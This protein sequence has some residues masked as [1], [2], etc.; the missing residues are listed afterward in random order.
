[1]LKNKRFNLKNRN[2]FFM[3]IA[4]IVIICIVN[5]LFTNTSYA[6][7]NILDEFSYA[8]TAAYLAGYDWTGLTSLWSYYYS[9]GY[10]L[11]LAPIF[12]IFDNFNIIYYLVLSLNLIF[13]IGSF[14]LSIRI[15]RELFTDLPQW[16][17]ILGC[18]CINLYT[19]NLINV[20][21]IWPETLIVFL[22][23]TVA[24]LLLKITQKT[25]YFRLIVLAI[26]LAYMYIVHQR[27]LVISIAAVLYLAITF[28]KDRDC[29]LKINVKKIMVFI[30]LIACLLMIVMHMKT[31]FV[32]S[33][34]YSSGSDKLGVNNIG[35][36]KSSI[37]TSLNLEGLKLFIKGAGGKVFY[38]ITSTIYVG[39]F[40]VLFCGKHLLKMINIC[41]GKEKSKDCS[42]DI[43]VFFLLS[44]L[45]MFLLSI[46]FMMGGGYERHDTLIYGRYMEY[47]Y[48]P[49]LLLGFYEIY[50]NDN[51]GKWLSGFIIIN[52][53]SAILVSYCWHWEGIT[54]YKSMVSSA[55]VYY[56]FFPD[57]IELKT[58]PFLVWAIRSILLVIVVVF[59]NILK[60]HKKAILSGLM[61]LC[62]SIWCFNGIKYNE[63]AYNMQIIDGD[64][65]SN[66]AKKLNEIKNLKHIYLVYDGNDLIDVNSKVANIKRLQVLLLDED[67]IPVNIIDIANERKEKN[68]A[69]FVVKE[70]EYY[71]IAF[72]IFLEDQMIIDDDEWTAFYIKD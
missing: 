43:S 35:G 70:S 13:L 34:Y 29:E 67:I 9:Y 22:F 49:I 48:G 28:Y 2:S 15:F 56:F 23:W 5:T 25:T 14:L 6:L 11:L 17:V 66:E 30:I 45:G 59:F 7:S 42:F 41:I 53:L 61:V 32:N 38:F 57:K 31:F 50:H 12:M 55:I 10:P 65:Y 54:Y 71:D 36:I 26:I 64:R 63:S 44:L 8:A 24:F 72:D 40:G 21:W 52:F 3:I 33:M 18:L 4:S 51:R 20:K 46:I 62:V 39:C 69:Y 68:S 1:M 19:S 47:V 58:I 16:L 27:T 37:S 60:K